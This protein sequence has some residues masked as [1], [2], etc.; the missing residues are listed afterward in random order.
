M[1]QAE[2]EFLKLALKGAA[3]ECRRDRLQDPRLGLSRHTNSL[4]DLKLTSYSA[5]HGDLLGER[6]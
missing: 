5:G 3:E 1:S 4:G 2:W 6:Q